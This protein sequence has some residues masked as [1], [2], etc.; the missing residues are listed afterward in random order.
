MKLRSDSHATPSKPPPLTHPAAPALLTIPLR[1]PAK[2]TL[3]SLRDFRRALFGP[4][5]A[6]NVAKRSLHASKDIDSRL[7]DVLTRASP[8]TREC[9]EQPLFLLSA[10]WRSGSTLLQ[11][12]LMEH[13]RDILVWGEPFDHSNIPE[14]MMTQFRSF[15][16]QWPFERFFLSKHAERTLSD[17]WVANLYPDVDYLLN[18]H[19]RFFD[20]LFGEPARAVGRTRWGFKE[21]RLTIDHAMYFRALY[22]KCKIVFLYRKPH[23]AY[24]SYRRLQALWFRSWPDELIATPYA[25][26]RHWANT[27]RGFLCGHKK[28]NGVVIR[29]EDLDNPAEV[30][31]IAN[32]LGWPVSRSSQLKRRDMA[33]FRETRDDLTGLDGVMLN[34]ATGRVRKDAGY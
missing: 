15:T 5:G 17:E 30:E 25:F 26:G 11:R 22:P 24:L 29:Y 27:T 16:A 14:C 4:A 34:F 9:D 31:R 32:Y 6:R 18:A 19:R 10:G 20:V 21:V 8:R 3:R 13:N 28:V 23:D 1:R 2:R 12:M 33:G 7:K